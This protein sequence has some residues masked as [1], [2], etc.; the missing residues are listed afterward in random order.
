MYVAKP[1]PQDGVFFLHMLRHRPHSLG[2]GAWRLSRPLEPYGDPASQTL[3]I[4]S[5]PPPQV[6]QLVSR[7]IP[8]LT[9]FYP[10]GQASAQIYSFQPSPVPVSHS[11]NSMEEQGIAQL[12]VAGVVIPQITL[13]PTRQHVSS[14]LQE[15]LLLA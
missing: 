1:M 6:S 15:K 14:R 10:N 9:H 13:P 4:R 7:S 3:R 8:L 5:P 2:S 11:I 12:N